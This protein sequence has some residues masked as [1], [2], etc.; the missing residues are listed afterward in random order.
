[1]TL[2]VAETLARWAVEREPESEVDRLRRALDV[3]YGL[4][5][6][7]HNVTVIK[8]FDYC[9]FCPVCHHSDGTEPEL[10]EIVAAL[11]KGGE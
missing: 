3:A 9:G 6:N 11:K 2:I 7:H 10:D 1:M 8:G 5:L 4:I